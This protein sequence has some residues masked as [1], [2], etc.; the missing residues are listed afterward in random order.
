MSFKVTCNVSRKQ[1]VL[2]ERG[3]RMLKKMCHG[4]HVPLSSHA[5]LMQPYL[6]SSGR[7]KVRRWR[8][9]RKRAS[10]GLMD[11][12]RLTPPNKKNRFGCSNRTGRRA[13][14]PVPAGEIGRP[15]AG[16][17][18]WQRP[19]MDYDRT[20]GG[21]EGGSTLKERAI[22]KSNLTFL[23]HF[24]LFLFSFNMASSNWPECWECT[25]PLTFPPT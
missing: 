13:G 2:K 4:C 8:R 10:T 14:K 25:F 18:S 6:F 16:S 11:L 21:R 17:L 3:T 20:W 15:F 9:R 22:K 23:C 19:E 1:N 7:E 24:S 12:C 5:V